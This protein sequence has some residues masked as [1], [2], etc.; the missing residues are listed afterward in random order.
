MR[1]FSV[2]L[3]SCSPIFD[4]GTGQSD[5]RALDDGASGELDATPIDAGVDSAIPIECDPGFTFTPV[6]PAPN[7]GLKLSYTNQIPFVFVGLTVTS[8]NTVDTLNVSVGSSESPYIWSAEYSTYG[9]GLYKVVFTIQDGDP[10]A[11]CD[12]LV[13]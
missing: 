5:A 8:P 9:P 13:E 4:A 2:F 11:S 7:S 1:R 6:A 3:S 10:L 12:F